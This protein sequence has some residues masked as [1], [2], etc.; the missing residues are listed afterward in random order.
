MEIDINKI[1]SAAEISVDTKKIKMRLLK[2]NDLIVFEDNKPQ[3]VILSLEKYEQVMNSK[4][5]IGDTVKN[6]KKIGKLVQDSFLKC[7]FV[8]HIGQ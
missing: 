1:V 4:K 2:N 5:S 7:K 3:F 6:E 8:N